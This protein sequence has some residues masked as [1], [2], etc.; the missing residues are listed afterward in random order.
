MTGAK[1][2]LLAGF[3]ALGLVLPACYSTA[4]LENVE[5]P[6]LVVSDM[7]LTTASYTAEYTQDGALSFT[8]EVKLGTDGRIRRDYVWKDEKGA[9]K[10]ASIVFNGKKAVK[11]E[12][13]K[14]AP[15]KNVDTAKARFFAGLILDPDSVISNATRKKDLQDADGIP[16]YDYVQPRTFSS[17]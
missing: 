17:R 5:P 6:A 4:Y 16:C 7:P 11:I 3:A 1:Q 8:C 10:K 14:S 15:A 13:G 2:I 9:E 12:D